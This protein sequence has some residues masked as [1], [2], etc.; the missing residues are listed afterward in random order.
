[1]NI[2]GKPFINNIYNTISEWKSYI[3]YS[4]NDNTD[5]DSLKILCIQGLYGYRSGILG[6][7]F[8]YVGYR[9][10]Q[11]IKP[12]FISSFSDD[13][14]S[15]DFEIVTLFISIITRVI[16]FYN[17]VTNDPKQIFVDILGFMNEN[18]SMTSMF[19]LESLFL[20][21]P[22]YDSGCAIY[23]NK[24]YKHCGFEKW[25]CKNTVSNKGMTWCYFE[26]LE[27]S[28]GIS[29]IN[30]DF[31]EENTDSEDIQCLKQII[32]LKNKLENNYGLSL[33][34][35]ETYI[36]GNFNIAFNISNILH[37][38]TDKLKILQ[39]E[40]FTMLNNLGYADSTEF[41]FYNKYDGYDII[42]HID[43]TTKSLE[44]NTMF[45]KIN[46]ISN[47]NKYST[48]NPLFMNKLIERLK[49]LEETKKEEEVKVEEVEEVKEE[50]IKVEEVK[51]EVK[52]EEIKVEE[53]KEEE[54]KEEEIK[55][56]EVKEEEEGFITSRLQ[57]IKIDD[58][59]NND[60]TRVVNIL[61]NINIRDNYF[62][63]INDNLY[64]SSST[65]LSDDWDIL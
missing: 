58:N 60:E 19:D 47:K 10:S 44:L 15:N 62:N 7:L 42:E 52:E 49:E 50:E 32:E 51:E 28:S 33:E 56:E 46:R 18:R 53:V 4:I 14:E 63:E 22:L 5:K 26:C 35:Y 41:I 36:V 20:L 12:K 65:S 54:K 64:L 38:I 1:M 8:D 55:I 25:C 37:E 11:Y 31:N 59:S 61:E 39:N 17:Y 24:K 48:I 30:L 6:K 9:L 29:V 34:T 21:K 40:G 43:L 13:I 3:Q 16:P 57:E 27:S 2:R 23:A 45:Y